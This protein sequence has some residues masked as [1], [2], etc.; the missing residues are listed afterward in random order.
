[1]RF[2]IPSRVTVHE[3]YLVYDLVAVVSAIGGTLGLCIGFSF[4][5]AA[6]MCLKCTEHGLNMI[7]AGVANYVKSGKIHG[8][9]HGTLELGID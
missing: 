6:R 2:V 8:R 4:R 3:E 5:D 1:M 9:N 7:S